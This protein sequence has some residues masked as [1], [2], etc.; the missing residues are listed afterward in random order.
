[1]KR[2]V[3]TAL[4]VAGL[5]VVGTAAAAVNVRMLHNPGGE[6][7]QFQMRNTSQVGPFGQ[8]PLDTS[9]PGLGKP[10]DPI[11]TPPAGGN[12]DDRPRPTTE[13]LVLLRVAAMVRMDPMRVQSIARGAVADAAPVAAV[14]QAALAV[15]TTLKALAVVVPPPLHE[16]GHGGPGHNDRDGRPGS[17]SSTATG[18]YDD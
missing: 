5:L 11:G 3:G 9:A 10:G 16:R 12:G 7:E 14:K 1:M 4:S 2:Y 13:Q 8:R 15:G 18:T 6:S 17:D